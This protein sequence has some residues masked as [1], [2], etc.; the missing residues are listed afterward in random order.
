MLI[1]NYK[2][3]EHVNIHEARNQNNNYSTGTLA[4]YV[5]EAMP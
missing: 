1:T 4:K 5:R 2:I 3:K